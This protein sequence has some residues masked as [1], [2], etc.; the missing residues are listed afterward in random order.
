MGSPTPPPDPQ[1]TTLS[2]DH[3]DLVNFADTVL[4]AYVRKLEGDPGFTAMLGFSG[5]GGESGTN[6]FTELLAGNFENGTHLHDLFANSLA[7]PVVEDFKKFHAQL[8]KSRL[9]IK[10][11]L[12]QMDDAH[13]HALT[14]AQMM[15]ILQDVIG[16]GGGGGGAGGGK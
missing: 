8:E 2:V 6:H 13:E 15:Q 14:A 3:D 5:K 4:P 10:D 9:D 7:G 1:V 12:R 16:A 11:F